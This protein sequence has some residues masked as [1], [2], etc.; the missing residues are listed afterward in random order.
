L[1]LFFLNHQL[2]TGSNAN[3]SGYT[4]HAD[5][6]AQ[7]EKCQQDGQNGAGFVNWNHFVDVACL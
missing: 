3:N 7:K 5:W 1:G 4:R 6:F 2:G